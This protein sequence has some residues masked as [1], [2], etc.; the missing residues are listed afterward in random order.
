M[1]SAN[2]L[3]PPSPSFS[4]SSLFSRFRILSFSLSSTPAP[5]GVRSNVLAPG[6]IAG[7]EGLSRLTTQSSQAASDYA[8]TGRDGSMQ[9]V[10]NAA[11][12]LFSPAARYITGQAINVDGGMFMS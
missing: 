9:D 12:F 8:P 4:F 1:H 6:P 11:V 10:A 2:L 3:L 7:T 5:Q